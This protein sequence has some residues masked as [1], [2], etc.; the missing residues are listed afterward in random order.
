MDLHH[1]LTASKLE[2]SAA[3]LPRLS[4]R[5]GFWAVAFAF[6]AVAAF[7]TAPSSLYGLYA[8]HDHVA[9][10]T[11]TIVYAVYAAGVTTSLLLVGHVSDWYGR[12]V[13]LIPAIAVATVA[14]VVF[15]SWQSLAGLIV[16]RVLTGLALGATVATATAYIADLDAGP[17]GGV[18]R[19]AEVISAIASVGGLAIGPLL[20]GLLARYASDGLT[21]PYVVL[22]VGL[23]AAVLAVVLTPEGHPAQHP[24]PAYRPQRLQA[25]AHAKGQF[26][27]ALTG[28][29]LAFATWG[30]F[31]GLAGRFL[32]QTLHHP[33][34]ALTGAAIFLTF[35]TGAVVQITTSKWPA[36]RLLV[37]GIPTIVLGLA[38]FVAS[39]WTSP[40]SLALFL[41]GG[42]VTSSGAAAIFRASLSVVIETASA[43][44]RA[45][46]L[47]TF[48]VVGYA[49]LSLPVLGLGIGLIYL[50]P[51]VT[52]LIFGLVVGLGVLAAAPTLLR[53]P[54]RGARHPAG[55][56]SQRALKSGSY[57]WPGGA[58][59]GIP[60]V[61]SGGERR[62][63]L[64]A[65][66]TR[67]LGEER[68]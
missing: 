38:I 66:T 28:V 40:P 21:L 57:R 48:F 39:A 14:A 5:A 4:R 9:P 60:R 24:L 32:A 58:D 50:S 56:R 33:S 59:Q 2:A 29:A 36:H 34:P 22:L 23:V 68:S 65:H 62:R 1:T 16:A 46:A 17:D 47:A 15:I 41:I 49:A 13:V 26:I 35:G 8:Q 25:P 61:R 19:R 20:T 18:T 30:I 52:L 42:V 67:S 31:A 64:V 37:A 51:Q 45:G 6:L 27:A 43:G 53:R 10:F 3:T 44:D 12:K 55:H 63:I 11:L 7:S 54:G